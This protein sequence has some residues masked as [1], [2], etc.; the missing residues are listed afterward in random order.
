MYSQTIMS[1][2]FA[3]AL[4]FS[5]G[6]PSILIYCVWD[7]FAQE[8]VVVDKSIERHQKKKRAPQFA[9]GM[10]VFVVKVKFADR[11]SVTFTGR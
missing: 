7:C 11:L 3:A 9:L 5:R 6:K 2:R 10:C 1:F 8:N 4:I